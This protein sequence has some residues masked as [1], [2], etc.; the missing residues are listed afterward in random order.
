[1]TE[2]EKIAK[3]WYTGQRGRI[4]GNTKDWDSLS[5]DTRQNIM[6]SASETLDHM[7]EAWQWT[8]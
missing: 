5:W 8:T 7:R 6:E 1:M 3:D 4:N 2:L